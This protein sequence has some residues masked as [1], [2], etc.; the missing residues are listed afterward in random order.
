[1][2]TCAGRSTTDTSYKE[3]E[4]MRIAME[5]LAYAA[6]VDL[7]FYGELAASKAAGFSALLIL[8]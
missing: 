6:G 7:F 5:P 8:K 2:L 4:Q 1:M 3:Y